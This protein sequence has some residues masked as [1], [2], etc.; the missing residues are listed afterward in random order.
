MPRLFV[1]IDFPPELQLGL[2]GLCIGMPGARWV[3]PGNFHLTLR[4][5][6]QVD[7][8]VAAEINS[9]LMRVNAPG[10]EL[11]L[12]GVGHFG[13]HTL[14]VGVEHNPALTCLQ[15]A[16][17]DQLQQIGLPADPRP[18]A[19]HVKLARLSRRGGL[20]AFLARNANFRAEP[21]AVRQ[22]SLIESH[23]GAHG[24]IYQHKTVYALQQGRTPARCQ[25]NFIDD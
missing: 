20:R 1:A 23:L 22:F 3:Q 6:G 14:W 24:P 12:A 10:F 21:F 19:P 4:F 16:I 13:W 18:F 5:I 8:A 15:A 7:Y 9:A 17:E 25:E 2:S 11:T